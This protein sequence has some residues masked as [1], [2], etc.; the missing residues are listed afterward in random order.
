MEN[1]SDVIIA[2]TQLKFCDDENLELTAEEINFCPS[3]NELTLGKALLNGTCDPEKKLAIVR[4]TNRKAPFTAAHEILHLLGVEHDDSTENIMDPHLNDDDILAWFYDEAWTS[5]TINKLTKNLEDSSKNCIKKT[6][7]LPAAKHF[8]WNR[9]TNH[10]K[11]PKRSNFP[12]ENIFC[13]KAGMKLWTG[14]FFVFILINSIICMITF[15]MIETLDR[16]FE[17]SIKFQNTLGC[18]R[19]LAKKM[20]AAVMNRFR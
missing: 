4:V 6:E 16:K 12:K 3:L 17:I 5:E 7:S 1:S 15:C 19:C 2:L 13:F 18:W 9:W 14:M 8:E 10:L 20:Q 11:M